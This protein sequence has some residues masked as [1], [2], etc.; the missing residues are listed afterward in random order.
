MLGN[1]L[2][3]VTDYAKSIE[4]VKNAVKE[5]KISENQIN[6]LAFRV[7]AWKYYKEML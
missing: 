6:D 4:A 1:D 3:I 2:I 7:I 5:G